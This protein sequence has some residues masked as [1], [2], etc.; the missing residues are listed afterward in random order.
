V[1][2][3]QKGMI[4]S[5]KI[6]ESDLT[7]KHS[8]LTYPTSGGG[9]LDLYE[10]AEVYQN[11]SLLGIGKLLEKEFQTIEMNGETGTIYYFV[12]DTKAEDAKSFMKGFLWSGND[13][14]SA[15]NPDELIFVTV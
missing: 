14:S 9:S 2:M 10:R 15:D 3:A 4:N 8:F 1:V 13:K 5:V 12:Y 7:E 11:N 6:K